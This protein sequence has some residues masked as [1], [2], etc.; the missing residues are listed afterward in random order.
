GAFLEQMEFRSLARRVGDGSGVQP[1]VP[2][3]QSRPLE[4]PAI[5]AI[6]TQAYQCVRDLASLEIW[7]ARAREA[8]LFAFDVETDAQSSASADICGVSLAVAPGQACYIPV[9]HEHAEGLSLDL[10]AR[11][12]QISLE[13]AL[14]RLKPLMEDPAVLKIAHNA[15]YDIAVLARC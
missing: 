5:A 3:P 14:E 13:A 2:S 6:D 15:K 8:G 10:A 12:E 7:I 1:A 9:G 4:A 11:P